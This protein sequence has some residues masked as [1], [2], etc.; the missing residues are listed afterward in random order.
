[1]SKEYAR[2]YHLARYHRRRDA[3]IEHLGGCCV[4]CGTT[5]DL[6][7]DHID[8]TTK[9]ID[10]GKMWGVSEVRFWTE[11]AKCQLLCRKHHI[12]KTVAEQM[13]EDHGTW[14]WA[15]KRKCPCEKCRTFINTYLRE[16]KRARRAA[17]SSMG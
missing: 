6:Q 16:W 3:A 8:P 15:G 2:T 7:L 10:V 12:E 11:I 5:E 17:S 9:L 13:T 14:A 4:V 1:M